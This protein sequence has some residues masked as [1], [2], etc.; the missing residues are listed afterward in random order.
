MKISDFTTDLS[1]GVLLVHL[2][3]LLSSKKLRTSSFNSNA[4]MKLVKI[5][6]LTISFSFIE[7]QNIVIVNI[8]PEGGILPFV[9]LPLP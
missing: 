9:S 4:K 1:D 3:E 2:L 8:G 7:Q 6:N 5:Q